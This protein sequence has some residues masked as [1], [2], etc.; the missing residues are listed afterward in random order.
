MSA[1]PVYLER[2]TDPKRGTLVAANP[3]RLSFVPVRAFWIKDIPP[4]ATRGGHAHKET[5]QLLICL[6]GSCLVWSESAEG[7]RSD[8]LTS[9]DHGL[10]V[11]RMT[12]II[13]T[14]FSS[15][16]ILLVL[17]DHPFDSFDYIRSH[18]EFERAILNPAV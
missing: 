4:E 18:D 12:W 8:Y 16:A 13:V 7:K 5:E 10:L 11:R 1:S 6:Q 15:D 2:F 9:P 17:A 14:E 3:E